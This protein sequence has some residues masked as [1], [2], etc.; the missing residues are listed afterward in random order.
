MT[1]T[2]VELRELKESLVDTQPIGSIVKCTK[3]LDQVD[4]GYDY[5]NLA[6]NY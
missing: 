5:L 4:H 3:T 2:E 6:G 1:K